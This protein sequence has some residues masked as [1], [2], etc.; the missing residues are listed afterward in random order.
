MINES[1]LLLGARES[2]FARWLIL[3]FKKKRGDQYSSNEIKNNLQLIYVI[4]EVQYLRPENLFG[5]VLVEG[6]FF[7]FSEGISEADQAQLRPFVLRG[8]P[9]DL[10]YFDLQ[11]TS[12]GLEVRITGRSEECLRDLLKQIEWDWHIAADETQSKAL[13][14]NTKIAPPDPKDIDQIV[15]LD[16]DRKRNALQLLQGDDVDDRKLEIIIEDWWMGVPA[17]FTSS[18][19]TRQRLGRIS[20]RRIYNIHHE[21]SQKYGPD[22]VPLRLFKD[23]RSKFFKEK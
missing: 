13:G 9:I 12:K 15:N 4:K 21:L 8:L 3:Y 23:K 2:E 10:F 6:A 7:Y 1:I 5:R 16:H 11:N 19:L 22:I 17:I 18:T 14:I 20:P